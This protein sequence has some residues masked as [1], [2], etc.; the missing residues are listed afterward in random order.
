[1]KREF[2]LEEF[3]KLIEMSDL[4]GLHYIEKTIIVNLEYNDKNSYIVDLYWAVVALNNCN[5][6]YE[7]IP[8]INF[9]QDLY[10]ETRDLLFDIL[11]IKEK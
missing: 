11:G 3:K 4:E 8:E 10:L 2:D 9:K 5:N 7:T 6:D 1:M